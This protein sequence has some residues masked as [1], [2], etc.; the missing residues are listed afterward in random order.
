MGRNSISLFLILSTPTV[1]TSQTNWFETLVKLQ[2]WNNGNW[3]YVCLQSLN[4]ISSGCR[5]SLHIDLWN[6]IWVWKVQIH[7]VLEKMAF[8]DEFE[9]IWRN[10]VCKYHLE[11]NKLH[12][13]SWRLNF[14]LIIYT[15]SLLYGFTFYSEFVRKFCDNCNAKLIFVYI[16]FTSGKLWLVQ[17]ISLLWVV[18][19]I[20]LLIPRIYIWILFLT[21]LPRSSHSF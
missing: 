19:S 3:N 2:S 15:I 8:H 7:S 13:L 9:C 11:Q 17:I 20:L 12:L 5:S 14:I 16:H 1:K 4:K 21:L 18:F 10:R 6:L